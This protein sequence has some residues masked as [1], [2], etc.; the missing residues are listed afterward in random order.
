MYESLKLFSEYNIFVVKEEGDT[1]QVNQAYEQ[2][3]ARSDKRAI[4]SLLDTTRTNSKKALSH[5]NLIPICLHA[6][7]M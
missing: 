2:A 3:V 4:R 6:L 7:K 5:F 1:Y